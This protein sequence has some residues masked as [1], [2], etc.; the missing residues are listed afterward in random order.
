MAPA[1]GPR[2][3]TGVSATGDRAE[4]A[5]LEAEL[6]HHD[7]LYYRKAEPEITD[8][9]YDD[10]RDRYL[11]LAKNL[12]I[13]EENRYGRTP[14]NDLTEGFQTVRHQVPMLSLEKASAQPGSSAEDQLR[15]W[16]KRTRRLLELP[17]GAALALAVE[18][19]I[20]GMSVSLTYTRDGLRQ[21][22]SRGDGER[23]D[24]ITAQVA[25]SGAVPLTLAGAD[26]WPAAAALEVRGELYLPRDAFDR[27]NAKRVAAGETKLVNPRNGCAGL[28]KNKDVERI[29]GVGVASF[30]YSVAQWPQGVALPKTQEACLHWLRGLGFTTPELATTVPDMEAAIAHCAVIGGKR[31]SLPYDIDG[32]VVKIDDLRRWA[33]L[34]ATSHSPR[35]GIAYKFAAERKATRLLDVVPQVGKSGKLTPVAWLEPVFIAG[36][37]VSRAS[38]HNY[39]ELERKDV[40]INDTVLIEKAGEIIPQVVEVV[41]DRRGA[42]ARPVT[43][44]VACPECAS[45]V[46]TEAIFIYCD[47]PA[48]P[49]QVRE[50]LRHFASRGAM[51][52][53]GMGP[54][55]IDQVV[56]KLGV[57]EP[58]Q[59]FALTAA[60]LE[61]LERMGAKSAVNVV[62]ALNGAKSRGLAR[63]LCGLAI[64]QI[65][66]SLSEDL[67]RSFGTMDALLATADLHATDPAAAIARLRQLENVAD[68][69]AIA[70]CT[71]LNRPDIRA[72]IASLVAQGVSMTATQT[73]VAAVA[74]VEGKTFV[75][76]G[77]L[78]TLTRPAAEAMIKA[79]GGKCSGSVSKKTDYVV[80]GAEAGS[81]LEKATAL[82]VAV[83]DEAAL[84]KL[85]GKS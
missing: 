63:V 37:T 52:I 79:A 8:T 12:E 48:C 70:V 75:L 30:L 39:P 10:L 11:A 41:L 44:P 77:T 27:Q 9:Q 69:T 61:S 83:I 68:T 29:R 60:Q 71:G 85:L 56:D 50:R 64:D 59:L 13:P 49:A 58:G 65:G 4:L 22:V 54:A 67:A 47:N 45:P 32:V 74:G 53:E 7:E 17:A 33:E 82:G 36:T 57:R 15:D 46:R 72:A 80:A 18:P 20:D 43:R 6:R 14:G 1:P 81:K 5:L 35:W 25:A 28:M 2:P 26:A 66:E 51:D 55:L 21:A 62:A 76:T 3:T 40:R 78:P 42:D 24:V 84:L 23:G 16:D 31:A 19:K 34:G 38:L 73:Q